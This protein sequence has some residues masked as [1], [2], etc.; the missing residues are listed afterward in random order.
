MEEKPLEEKT[1]VEKYTVGKE[2]K[3]GLCLLELERTN[4]AQELRIQGL[5]EAMQFFSEWYNKTQRVDL[6]VP[7]HLS[8]SNNT[9]GII[10]PSNI[11]S[12][13][14]SILD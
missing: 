11:T 8:S 13:T 6:L 10:L 14:K 9:G 3:V 5:E 1:I 7:E 4:K 12:G 2:V